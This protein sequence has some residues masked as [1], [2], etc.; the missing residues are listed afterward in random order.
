MADIKGWMCVRAAITAITASSSLSEL[1]RR[2]V[3]FTGDVDTVATIAL[4][5]GS[6]SADIARDLPA[7]LIAGLENG[8]YGRDYLVGLDRQLLGLVQASG[9]A[10]E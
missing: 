8:P 2:C 1:L 10:P 3:A 6:C 5:A 7:H 4:A 9:S